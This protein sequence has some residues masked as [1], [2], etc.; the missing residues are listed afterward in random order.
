MTQINKYLLGALISLIVLDFG[1]TIVA[2]GY[3]G[4]CEINPLVNI[5]FGGFMILKLILSALC[6][7]GISKVPDS[8]IKT[9]CLS[10]IVLFYGAIIVSNLSQLISYFG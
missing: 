3:L 7:I 9:G 5:G 8:M 4:A 6:V 10:V 2:V 1:T